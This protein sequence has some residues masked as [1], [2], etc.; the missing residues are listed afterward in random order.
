MRGAQVFVR[1]WE[2]KLGRLLHLFHII[3]NNVFLFIGLK[4][5]GT[6]IWFWLV[7]SL[8]WV[9]KPTTN[10]NLHRDNFVYNHWRCASIYRPL[11]Y[12]F[13]SLVFR[14]L[15]NESLTPIVAL[16]ADF[17]PPNNFISR[18]FWLTSTARSL[19]QT[20]YIDYCI[21]YWNNYSIPF[22]NKIW[23]FYYVLKSMSFWNFQL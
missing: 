23:W 1:G 7:G 5:L 18:R 11:S 4:T 14:A 22:Y 13:R 20:H 3:K 8:S 17:P 9:S 15:T 2:E 10:C 6:F 12:L 21:C 19:N 16:N